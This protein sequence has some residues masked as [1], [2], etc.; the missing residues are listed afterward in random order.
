MKQVY[1]SDVCEK[2]QTLISFLI[3]NRKQNKNH[4]TEWAK[5]KCANERNG[6]EHIQSSE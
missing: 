1:E 4:I 2:S 3:S 6:R 5:R